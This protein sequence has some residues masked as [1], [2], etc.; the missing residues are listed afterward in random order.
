MRAW[1]AFDKPLHTMI[2]PCVD[3]FNVK[4]CKRCTLHSLK[5]WVKHLRGLIVA[6]AISF[7][8]CLAEGPITRFVCV[9]KPCGLFLHGFSQLAFFDLQARIFQIQYFVPRHKFALACIGIIGH[10]HNSR[11]CTKWPKG[12]IVVRLQQSY[13]RSFVYWNE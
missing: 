2:A 13:Q 1:L 10:D 9:L 8:C 11:F 6:T 12:G 4:G 3:A 7:V 5:H